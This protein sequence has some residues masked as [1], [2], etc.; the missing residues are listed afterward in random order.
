MTA[1]DPPRVSYPVGCPA[2]TVSSVYTKTTLVSY[3][4]HNIDENERLVSLSSK[5]LFLLFLHLLPKTNL[6]VLH[7][8]LIEGVE[9]K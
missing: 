3:Q 7:S 5:T 2:M 9:I 4:I 8:W 6:P 1:F